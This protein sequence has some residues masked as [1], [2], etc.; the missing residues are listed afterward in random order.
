MV[1]LSVHVFVLVVVISEQWDRQEWELGLG[2]EIN[3][4]AWWERK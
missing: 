2:L 3:K 4:W 1:G